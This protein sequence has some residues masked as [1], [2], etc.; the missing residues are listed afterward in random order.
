[1]EW[2]YVA[3]VVVVKL[4][5]PTEATSLYTPFLSLTQ[6]ILPAPFTSAEPDENIEAVTE[7]GIFGV[8]WGK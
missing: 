6:Y 5:E 2:L 3:D 4:I 8:F 1:M 7:R